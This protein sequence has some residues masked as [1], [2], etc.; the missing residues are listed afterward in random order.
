MGGRPMLGR[1]PSRTPNSRL[2]SDDEDQR[3][4][5]PICRS[6]RRPRFPPPVALNSDRRPQDGQQDAQHQREVARPHAGAGAHVVGGGAPGKGHADDHEH[7]AG[8]KVFLTLDFHEVISSKW[9]SERAI[10]RGTGHRRDVDFTY[11]GTHATVSAS[12]RT[13][14]HPGIPGRLR[15]STAAAWRTAPRPAWS[16]LRP[17]AGRRPGA[18]G[19]CRRPR[20]GG[21]GHRCWARG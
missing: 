3:A 8:E 19:A 5:R 7:E 21:A 16:G 4:S 2:A 9:I 6:C 12:H 20:P 18:A 14:E 1:P 17:R 15:H 10:L 13:H 11:A